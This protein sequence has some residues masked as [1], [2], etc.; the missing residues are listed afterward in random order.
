MKNECDG[1]GRSKLC[2]TKVK[3]KHCECGE[4]MMVISRQCKLCDLEAQ[5]VS[6]HNSKDYIRESMD[7]TS[8]YVDRRTDYIGYSPFKRG[9]DIFQFGFTDQITQKEIDQKSWEARLREHAIE[10]LSEQ[11]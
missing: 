2:S 11:A 4:P 5:G 7:H 6:I 1:S 9:E 8:D 10:P 3:H